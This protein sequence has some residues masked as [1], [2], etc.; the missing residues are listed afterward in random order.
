MKKKC[1]AVLLSTM[2]FFGFG[3]NVN[4]EAASVNTE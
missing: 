4:L 2:M 1:A 3:M